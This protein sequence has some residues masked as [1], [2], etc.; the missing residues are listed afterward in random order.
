LG[1][2][3][4]TAADSFNQIATVRIE[5]K[6]RPATNTFETFPFRTA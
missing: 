2:N 3:S 5:L 4:P 1:A 6:D